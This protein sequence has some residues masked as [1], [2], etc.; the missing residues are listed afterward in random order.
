VAKFGSAIEAMRGSEWD[1]ACKLFVEV[2]NASG[3]E[4][5]LGDRARTYSRICERRLAPKMAEPTDNEERYYRAVMLVNSGHVRDAIKLLDLALRE[6]PSSVRCLYAR[7]SAWAL[8]GRV[9]AAVADLRQAVAADPRVRFQA[10]N[11]PDFEKI[12][13]EPPFIDL[14]EPTPTGV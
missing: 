5:E 11:D 2:A 9:D 4:P 6:E 12:R 13:E 10:A 3:D 1:R 7:A 14:I 8:E